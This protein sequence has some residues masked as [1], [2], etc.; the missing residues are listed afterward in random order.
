LECLYIQKY[1]GSFT[2]DLDQRLSLLEVEHNKIPI[3]LK[4]KVGGRKV[5][6]SGL[7]VAIKTLSFFIDL[8]AI[9]EIKNIYGI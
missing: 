8:R 3:G 6:L 9:G 5:G 2:V 4:K 1:N 7:R